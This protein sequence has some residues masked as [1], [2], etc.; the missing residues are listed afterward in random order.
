[1]SCLPRYV[2]CKPREKRER[3]IEAYL[4]YLCVNLW[5]TDP[6]ADGREGVSALVGEIAVLVERTGLV[7]VVGVML[8]SE[9]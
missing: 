9:W 2:S 7:V 5:S 3:M 4:S 6:V 8:T 1:M